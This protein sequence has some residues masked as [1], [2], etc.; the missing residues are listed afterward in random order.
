MITTAQFKTLDDLYGFY[1]VKLFG[2][3]LPECIV[4]LS[5]RP[6]S[7]GY[8]VPYL[9]KSAEVDSEKEAEQVHEISLNP[10]YMR[11]A[12][13]EWHATL[14][15][16]MVHL[17]QKE[18]AEPCREA[19]HDKVW[20]SKMESL[21]LMASETGEPGGKK[22]GQKVTHYIIQ[23]GAFEKV[24]NSIDPEMHEILRLKYLPVASLHPE[25]EDQE[26]EGENGEE[27][28]E[29]GKKSGRR[30]KYSCGC[31]NNIWGRSGLK[32]VC[33]ECGEV[34]REV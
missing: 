34:Y 1:N 28:R 4:N 24:F 20:A 21:G 25:K 7:K 27:E 3:A 22:T 14:V 12:P 10:D 26:N 11:R 16:E 6:R 23:G 13:I 9:W 19:Y 29:S 17:W 15:H 30:A 8:F 2:A 18:L 33:V 32:V 31:G 5:R